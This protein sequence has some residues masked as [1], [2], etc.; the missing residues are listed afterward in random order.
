[1]AIYRMHQG[2]MCDLQPGTTYSYQV[3][4]KNGSTEYVSPVYTFHT[5]P[6]VTANPDAESIIGVL[7]DSR[8]SAQIWGQLAG[9]L[10]TQAVDMMLFSGDAVVVGL[11]Q[12]E[13][14]AWLGSATD[15]LPT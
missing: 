5:A 12:G 7:G 11:D 3:G 14:D 9:E 15:V 1:M 10:Q 6:D 8:D 2:H 13:W 4:A